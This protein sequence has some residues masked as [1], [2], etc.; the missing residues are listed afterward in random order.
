MS[1]RT[2]EAYH[3]GHPHR[4]RR[5]VLSGGEARKP[6]R[7]FTGHDVDETEEVAVGN[8]IFKFLS[9]NGRTLMMSGIGQLIRTG[10]NAARRTSGPMK[11]RYPEMAEGSKGVERD[12]FL[13]SKMRG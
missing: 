3:V 5:Q 7:H 10:R 9:W 2:W 13:Q 12:P 4:P 11:R 1:K 8:E 6:P